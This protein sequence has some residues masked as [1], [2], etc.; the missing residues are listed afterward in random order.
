MA[1]E[2]TVPTVAGMAYLTTVLYSQRLKG[3]AVQEL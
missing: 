3:Q 2:T 1:D